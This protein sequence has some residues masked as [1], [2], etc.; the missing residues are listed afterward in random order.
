MADRRDLLEF[1][2]REAALKYKKIMESKQEL[3]F[4]R[5]DVAELTSKLFVQ[6]LLVLD[7]GCGCGDILN[8]VSQ[9]DGLRE[10]T[11]LMGVDIAETMLEHAKELVP[12][13]SFKV[14]DAVSLDFAAEKSVGGILCTFVTH[15]LQDNEFVMA[16]H[17]FA[18]V[19]AT[20]CPVYHC[21]WHG[22]G[23]MDGF[24]EGATNSPTLLKRTFEQVDEVFKSQGFAKLHGR[25]ETYEWGDMAFDIYVKI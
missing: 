25:R 9:S 24:T 3:D 20:G 22:E 11:S 12:S 21:Y 4:Y 16:V 1:Y 23:S 19:A 14:G 18:R 5:T 2:S 17:E 15:H 10:G 7:V 8:L 13:A 6:N